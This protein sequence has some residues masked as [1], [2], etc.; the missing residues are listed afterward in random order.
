MVIAWLG[1]SS[2]AIYSA[3]YMRNAWPNTTVMGLKIWFHIHRTLNFLSVLLMVAS[4]VFILV[5]KQ[6][7]TGPWFG[8]DQIGLGGW[9]SLAG[10]IAV[11]FALGQP[12]GA[13]M[14]C[15]V[16]HPKRPIF[17]WLHRGLVS[18]A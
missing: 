18:H 9:H 7:W 11:F 14:R 5:N 2:V 3:R 17:N 15:G 13:L 6:R 1:M 12:F 16:D 8:R 10:A 4:I